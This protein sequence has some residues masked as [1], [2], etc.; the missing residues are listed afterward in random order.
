[1]LHIP[2]TGGTS[3]KRVFRSWFG[4]GLMEHYFDSWNNSMPTRHELATAHRLE[5]PVVV[6]G[7][8]NALRGFG[9]TDYYP[10]VT[11]FITILR[12]PFERALSGYF[13]IRQQVQQGASWWESSEPA[14][15]TLREYL[16]RR[17]EGPLP[18]FSPIPLTLDNFK[19]VIE[20]SFV[21]VGILERLD[22]SLR[23]IAHALH[24]DYDSSMLSSE[25]QSTRDQDIPNDLRE[26]FVEKHPLEYA[27]YNYVARKFD[28]EEGPSGV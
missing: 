25:N 4:E 10:Q 12:D 22:E 3:V 2:K 18:T 27:I 21:E 26:E 1:M 8:F 6:Y 11:Q 7:H 15:M 23:R 14:K 20:T 9:V 13:Y 28:H 17:P 5:R 16:S 24:M 19:D